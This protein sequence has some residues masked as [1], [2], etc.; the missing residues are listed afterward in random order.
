MPGVQFK[1]GQ[2]LAM[3]EITEFAHRHDCRIGWDLAHAIGNVPLDLHDWQCDFAVWCHYKYLNAGPGAI[4]GCFVHEQ[5]L[6]K[7]P[8]TS[9]RLVGAFKAIAI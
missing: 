3:K 6:E 4:G 2:V 5:Y 9:G 1:T 8:P 7:P